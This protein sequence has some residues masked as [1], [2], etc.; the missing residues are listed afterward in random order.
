MVAPPVLA[1]DPGIA[2][3]AA[4]LVGSD[5]ALLAV[6]TWRRTAPTKPLTVRWWATQTEGKLA[7]VET[8][9]RLGCALERIV[10][11]DAPDGYRLVVED[12]YVGPS[13]AVAIAS[14]KWAGAAAGPLES[15]MVGPATWVR[16]AVWRS[17]AFGIPMATK[18][19]AAKAATRDALPVALR[20]ALDSH[21]DQVGGAQ[22]CIDALG[23]AVWAHGVRHAPPEARTRTTQSD[24]DGGTGRGR[25][26][27][28]RRRKA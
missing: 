10:R 6:A 2:G 18:R 7:G 27:S 13:P 11:L 19:D 28:R 21:V 3:G 24:S 1:V 20:S 4:V 8:A 15:R 23:L 12:L 16:A 25:T 9:W 5:D 26:P 14:A 17:Q 22:H